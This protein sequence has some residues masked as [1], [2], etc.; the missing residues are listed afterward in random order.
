MLRPA[1]IRQ[2]QTSEQD[3]L[4]SVKD[5]DNLVKETA[6]RTA[7]ASIVQDYCKWV[8]TL[9]SLI[10]FKEKISIFMTSM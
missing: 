4:M 7:P 10:G 2:Q 5:V 9:D 6:T 8:F 1:P 3:I